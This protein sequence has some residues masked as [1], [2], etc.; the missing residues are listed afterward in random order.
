MKK[1]VCVWLVV[2]SLLIPAMA[3]NLASASNTEESSSTIDVA[4]QDGNNT[5]T[6]T[7]TVIYLTFEGG[8]WGIR[9]DDGK[10]YLPRDLPQELQRVG[11][12]AE[13]ELEIHEDWGSIYGWGIVVNVLHYSEISEVAYILMV[14]HTRGGSVTP[15]AGE[16]YSY[17]PGAVIDLV[18]KPGIGYRFVNWS[19]DVDTIANVNAAETTITMNGNYSITANFEEIPVVQ[20]QLTINS[21]EG[22]NVTT[23]GEGMFTYDEGTVVNLVATPDSGYRFINWTGNVS[24]IANVTTPSTNIIM[25]GNYSIM[26]NFRAEVNWAL[27]GGIISLVVVMVLLVFFLRRKVVKKDLRWLLAFPIY[28]IIGTIMH[29]GSHAL[30]AIAEGARITV[31]Q[32]WPTSFSP[33]RFGYVGWHGYTTWFTRAAPYFSG[34]IVFLVALLIVLEAKPRRRWLWL[35]I[36]I[37]GMATPLLNSALNYGYWLAGHQNDIAELL[38]HLDPVAVHLYFVLTMLFYAWGLYYCYFRKK[39]PGLT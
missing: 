20:Y 39:G 9:G 24:T 2:I 16:I 26:A 6:V 19:G 37:I 28:A 15:P 4:S 35:N 10:D 38:C 31:F 13:F 30:A 17:A 12:R 27:I 23:P 14:S 3:C 33:V 8:F 21:T 18:A 5:V 1:S 36:L 29:E 34:L 11:L 25:S 7:G 32:F 22:G